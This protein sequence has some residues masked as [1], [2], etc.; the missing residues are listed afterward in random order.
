MLISLK[1]GEYLDVHSEFNSFSGE[2]KGMSPLIATVLLIA[3]AVA[4]GAM[5]M[6]WSSSIGESSGPD[7]SAITMIINPFL[8]YADN[9]IKISIK[10]TGEAVE[11][12]S[13]KISDAN[14]ET[15]VLLKN[16]KLSKGGVLRREIPFVKTTKT[17]VGLVPSVKYK[18]QTTPCPDPIIEIADLPE[19]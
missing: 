5:I 1:R 12:V 19:C 4:L 11:A 18:D 16:S 9:L 10:N 2:K 14:I 8:C 15:D 3:F 6:N 13:V 7:C 17:Y